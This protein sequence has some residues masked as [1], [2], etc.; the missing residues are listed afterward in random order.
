M[1]SNGQGL[2]V[3]QLSIV[4]FI[5]FNGQT[6]TKRHLTRL[7]L[8]RCTANAFNVYAVHPQSIHPDR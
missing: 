2:A 1:T 5:W 4:V 6:L 8:Y 7:I 3:H